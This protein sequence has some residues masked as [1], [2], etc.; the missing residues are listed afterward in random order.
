MKEGAL[1]IAEQIKENVKNLN[2]LHQS[3][4]TCSQMTI[5]IGV[6]TTFA[7]FETSEIELITM[8]DK[9]L[10]RA[11]AEGRNRISINDAASSFRGDP[12]LVE[13]FVT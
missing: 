6:A 2:I 13:E 12:I 10:Y 1:N 4:K 8:A 3:S 7:G 9:A 11:K 5:S